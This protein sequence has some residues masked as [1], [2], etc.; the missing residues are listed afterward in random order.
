MSGKQKMG[1]FGHAKDEWGRF[2]SQLKQA[3][4]GMDKEL[5][6][7]YN[8]DATTA[9]DTKGDNQPKGSP[10][11][12]AETSE[13][14]KSKNET[15]TEKE[16]G[17]DGTKNEAS[18][19]TSNVDAEKEKEIDLYKNQLHDYEPY[20]YNITLSCVSPSQFN[21]GR[22]FAGGEMILKS[23][24]KPKQGTGNL[25]ND[26]YI[27]NL[28]IRN[29]IS[30][31]RQAGL[32]TVYQ[33]L[34]DVVEPYGTDFV[35]ALLEAAGKMGYTNHLKAV[36]RLDIEFKGYD[37][38]GKP[39]AKT[40]PG[41]GRSIFLHFYSVEL[42]VEAGVTTYQV[43]AVP[44]QQLAATEVHSI[45][46]ESVTCK[47]KNVQE[48]VESFFDEY[49]LVL[50]Q[51]QALTK[52]LQP[53][54]HVLKV[55][56][57]TEKLLKSP[58][59][60]DINESETRTVLN[61]SHTNVPGVPVVNVRQITVPKG[62]TIQ[63]FLEEVIRASEFYQDQFDQDGEP[64]DANGFLQIGRIFHRMRILLGD[65]GN[66]RPCYQFMYV[67]RTQDVSASY[68]D[69]QAVEAGI[70]APTRVYNYIHTGANTD[71]LDFNLNYKFAYYQAIPYMAD[72]S[73]ND[74]GFYIGSDRPD[75]N[76]AGYSAPPSHVNNAKKDISQV[77]REVQDI[78]TDDLIVQNKHEHKEFSRIFED[79]IKDPSADLI[80]VNMEILG[81]PCWI[82]HKGASNKSFANTFVPETRNIDKHG[83]VQP[84]EYEQYIRLNYNP[85][86]DIDDATGLFKLK[87]KGA[88]W[89]SGRYKVFLAENRFADGVYTTVLEMVRARYQPTDKRISGTSNQSQMEKRNAGPDMQ[90]LPLISIEFGNG[91]EESD[92]P[93]KNKKYDMDGAQKKWDKGSLPQKTEEDKT[94]SNVTKGVTNNIFASAH[95]A[96][97]DLGPGNGKYNP[98]SP[99]YVKPKS[100][101]LKH[102]N[103][104]KPILDSGGQPIRTG[105]V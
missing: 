44:A 103:T 47:G 59:N 102:K 84:D 6:K 66:N 91:S 26:Y 53:D 16:T 32:G 37:D 68:F 31:T 75:G 4:A 10:H 79:L 58:I 104:G 28:V 92:S 46:Q 70:T 81:D 94:S 83:S 21:I 24:G 97:K 93:V 74:T 78:D 105:T 11:K 35:D 101:I 54:E 56:D 67:L 77:T 5:K 12:D 76:P 63:Q 71:V 49:N 52:V 55:V 95:N 86:V 1:L 98:D 90:P 48:V 100:G 72:A 34:F 43:Q 13:A 65:N 33:V 7:S 51:Q 15:T 30:P 36:Y 88:S 69:K 39:S 25:A 61:F 3:N 22:Q 23:G 42:N 73:S 14:V 96:F 40:I 45:L 19:T 29:T 82:Q 62:T 41:T 38:D 17:S 80:A 27:N 87:G 9:K 85:P 57:C 20:N 2:S 18:K 60:Y 89:F 99:N 8:T 64:K 50:K